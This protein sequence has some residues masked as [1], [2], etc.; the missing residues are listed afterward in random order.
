[1]SPTLLQKTDV[2]QRSQTSR[3]LPTWPYPRG[4]PGGADSSPFPRLRARWLRARGFPRRRRGLRVLGTFSLKPFNLRLQP[5]KAPSVKG[6]KANFP[7]VIREESRTL[8]I[9]AAPWK[10]ASFRA[11]PASGTCLSLDFRS[12]SPVTPL[13]FFLSRVDNNCF[14]LG[15]YLPLLHHSSAEIAP[16]DAPLLV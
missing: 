2:V 4:G 10:P 1:M 11:E 3:S 16:A 14:Y 13:L 6:P 8:L 7:S 15:L 5:P 9:V 12:A